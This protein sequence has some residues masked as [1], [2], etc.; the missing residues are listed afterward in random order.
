MPRQ[1]TRLLLILLAVV[2]AAPAGAAESAA[3]R[4]LNLLENLTVPDND[5]FGLLAVVN[6]RAGLEKAG[7]YRQGAEVW[8]DLPQTYVRP[9]KRYFNDLNSPCFK[10]ATAIQMTKNMVRVVLVPGP[11]CKDQL[12]PKLR[13]DGEKTVRL[14]MKDFP[15]AA[16]QSAI[17]E[18][19][20]QA[21]KTEQTPEAQENEKKLKAILE[22]EKEREQVAA[23]APAKMDEKAAD[24]TAGIIA[25]ETKPAAG[26]S[27]AAVKMAVALCSVLAA[28]FFLVYLAKR[29]RL[30]NRLTG[31][32]LG[33]IRVIQTGMLDLKRR[34]AVVDVAGEL[35]V[36]ALT[37]DSVTML[38]KLESAEARRRLL[39]G[40]AGEP[41]DP[42]SFHKPEA[43]EP[44][45][46]YHQTGAHG[47]A[48]EEWAARLVDERKNENRSGEIR[49]AEAAAWDAPVERRTES[50]NS[51]LRAYTRHAPSESAAA[52]HETLQAI[53][54]RV[55]DLKRL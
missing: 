55:K 34:V 53:A 48:N 3:L 19:A 8:L 51:K 30:P 50:F 5:P 52:G 1:I 39:G 11:E 13:V 46:F 4:K 10:R 35:I 20:L 49:I 21:F 18:L 29:F 22:E 42:T 15:V 9:G 37:K 27:A 47:G 41:A 6:N 26:W 28:I 45:A 38:T 32:Q 12:E 44:G 31:G 24:L 17:E 16:P 54:K 36:V 40:D 33:Q 14:T 2:V 7:V 23:A 25:S 43:V